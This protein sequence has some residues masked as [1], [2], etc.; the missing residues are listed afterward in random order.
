MKLIPSTQW[1]IGDTHRYNKERSYDFALW[2]YGKCEDYD[3]NTENQMMKTIEDLVPKTEILKYIKQNYDVSFVLEI[4]PDI[5]CG[6]STPSLGP[7]RDIIKFCYETETSIDIDL[8]INQLD[9][10]FY[11]Q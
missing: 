4:V 3:V 8:Y 9:H 1:H 5:Y 7:N 2:E 10:M 11:K 6:E